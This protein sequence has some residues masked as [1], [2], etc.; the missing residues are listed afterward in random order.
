MPTGPRG[1]KRPVSPVSSMVKAMRVATG[2][3]KE[4][5][6]DGKPKQPA[7]AKSSSEDELEDNEFEMAALEIAKPK[8]RKKKKAQ[9]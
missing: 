5:Y 4:E 6:I 2:I 9:P 7:A 3:E 1:E 8:K